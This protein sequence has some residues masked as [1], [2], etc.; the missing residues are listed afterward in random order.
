MNRQGPGKIEWTDYTW[1]P[2]TGCKH[3]CDYCYARRIAE[4]FGPSDQELD[5]ILQFHPLMNTYLQEPIFNEKRQFAFP[6]RFYPTCHAYRFKEPQEITKPSKIFVSS[7][8]DLFGEWV[9]ASWIQ[10]ILSIVRSCP[11]HTFQFL[12]KNPGRLPDF[13]PWPENCWVGFTA[14][15]GREFSDNSFRGWRCEARLRFVCF[16]PI[17]EM[18]DGVWLEGYQ[19]VIIG[20]QTGPKAKSV[21][22]E[23][24]SE[25]LGRAAIHKVPIFMKSNLRPYW[26]GELRQ[27]FPRQTDAKEKSK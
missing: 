10:K 12:T 8:G 23:W 17:L 16:E 26:P 7:M 22:T 19:W 14:T 24:I 20:A 15:T 18:M 4:R 9:P 3:G 1:N 6:F 5:L 27:E 11:Q 13:N 25:L 21:P 2:V